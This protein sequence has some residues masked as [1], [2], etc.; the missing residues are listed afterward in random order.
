MEVS[1]EIGERKDEIGVRD[2]VWGNWKR[3]QG[4][5][6]GE[7]RTKNKEWENRKKKK[8]KYE[9]EECEKRVFQQLKNKA[10]DNGKGVLRKIGQNSKWLKRN[11]T[12]NTFRRDRNEQQENS[13]AGNFGDTIKQSDRTENHTGWKEI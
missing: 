3:E 5:R 9:K 13:A 11:A 6:E 8:G 7:E 10:N 4:E 1:H 2:E 12:I